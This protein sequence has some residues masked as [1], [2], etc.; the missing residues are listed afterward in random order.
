MI[1]NLKKF[2]IYY[3]GGVQAVHMIVLFLLIFVFGERMMTILTDKSDAF[4]GLWIS[5]YLDFLVA[6]PLGILFA[7]GFK[8]LGIISLSAAFFS[9]IIYTYSLVSVGAFTLSGANSIINILF[10]P[11]ILLFFLVVLY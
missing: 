10:A 5:A 2:L 11:V 4:A 8:K 7:F 3:Y 6:C 9:A 1:S